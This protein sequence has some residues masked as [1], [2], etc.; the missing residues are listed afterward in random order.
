MSG[1]NPLAIVPFL[2]M[3]ILCGLSG[4]MEMLA[5][6][7]TWRGNYKKVENTEWEGQGVV[8]CQLRAPTV[9]APACVD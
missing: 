6:I 4:F 5:E 3:E 1:W 9:V 7:E 8:C 2:S